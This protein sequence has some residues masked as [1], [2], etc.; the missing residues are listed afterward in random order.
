M[1]DAKG[2][3]ALK[4]LNPDLIFTLLAALEGYTPT[5]TARAVDPKTGAAKLVLVANDLDRRDPELILSGRVLDEDGK[6]VANAAVEPFGFLKGGAGHFG[7]LN[8]FDALTLTNDKGAFRL[9]VPEKGLAVTVRVSAPRMAKRNCANLACGPKGQDLTLYYGVTVVGRLLDK[10]KPLVGVGVGLMQTDRSAQVFVGEMKAATD[11]TG[12]F[13]IR[14]VPPNESV[15]F[16]GLM[17]GLK[18]HG[19]LPARHYQTGKSGNELDVGDVAIQPGLRLS[20]RLVLADSQPIPAGTRIMLSREDAW[21]QQQTI[22]GKDGSFAF[23][24]LPPEGYS[25]SVNVRGYVVS[26]KNA[27]LDLLN[28]GGLIGTVKSDVENL[29][30]LMEKG[31]R[32]ANSSL[33]QKTIEEHKRRQSS[34]LRGAPE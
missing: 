4:D 25:L 7:G 26:P 3:F 23:K 31:S 16:Y 30:F 2:Q 5:Q 34:P 32:A 13:H 28:R 8:G 6:P 15:A 1:T 27:S 21:D 17:D 12:T 14:N 11:E 19:S 29:R 33:D 24:G 20:G 10:G 22:V 9:G 18:E